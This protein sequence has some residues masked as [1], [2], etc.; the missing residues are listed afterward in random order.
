MPT[1]GRVQMINLPTDMRWS[2][3]FLGLSGVRN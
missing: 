2:S 3:G 1:A